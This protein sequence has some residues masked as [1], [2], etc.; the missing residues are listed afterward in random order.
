MRALSFVLGMWAALAAWATTAHSEDVALIYGQHG[1][2]ISLFKAD[3]ADTQD[4]AKPLRQAG[5]RVIEPGDNSAEGMRLAAQSIEDAIAAEPVDRL[6]IVV[7]APMASTMR[8]SWVMSNQAEGAS[9]LTIGAVGVS[10]NALS[11]LASRAGGRAVIL[12]A[13]DK[14]PDGLAAGLA[15]GL[16]GFDRTVGV[17]YATGPSAALADLLENDFLAPAKTFADVARS[18]PEGVEMSGFLSGRV[19]LMDDI[20]PTASP[21]VIEQGFW[22]A[23]QMIDTLEAYDAYLDAYAQGPHRAAALERIKWLRDEP[24]RQARDA[25][26]ALNLTRDARRGIQRDLSLLG[27]DPRGIDGVFGPGSR[28]AMAAWQRKNGVEETG[29]VTGNQLLRLREQANLRAAELEE[30]ARLLRE[31]EERADRA[32][33]RDTGREGDEAGLRAYLKRYPD[34]QFADVAQTRLAEIEEARRAETAREERDAW[35][36]TRELNTIPAYQ[37]FLQAYPNSGFADAARDR[38]FELEEEGK[39]SAAF[40]QARAEERKFAG[41][42]VARLLVEQRLAQLGANPGEIDGKFDKQTRQAIRRFQRSRKLPVTGFVSKATMV[43]L[44]GGK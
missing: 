11:D 20:T 3:G 1:Q 7:L 17:T 24:E 8:D 37:Q 33:W 26:A 34:G 18:V 32:F 22:Q 2:A 42:G 43:Q 29:F 15:P 35:D 38:L 40:E 44:L 6:V 31:Q 21:E 16:G 4:F 25:E 10:L 9:G 12:V 14:R 5:F 39:N 30:E 23:V 28:A 19:G 36:A 41:T 13:S 27:F